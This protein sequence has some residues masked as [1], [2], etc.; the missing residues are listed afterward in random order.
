VRH[1]EEHGLSSLLPMRAPI[2]PRLC[3][4]QSALWA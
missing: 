4:E 2:G 3:D 1:L